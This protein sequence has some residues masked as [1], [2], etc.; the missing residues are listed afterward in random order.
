MIMNTL[1]LILLIILQ[2]QSV[3]KTETL[4]ELEVLAQHI[5][6]DE[7]KN[8]YV[9]D[10]PKIMVYD[11]AGFHDYS[12]SNMYTG[13]IHSIDVSNPEQILLFYKEDQGIRFIN[14]YFRTIPQPFS[15]TEKGYQDVAAACVSD[16]D[17]L[18]IFENGK[19]QLTKL[20]TQGDFITQGLTLN[21]Q[22]G[23][24]IHPAYMLFRNGTLY[25][26]D[27]EK[28]IFLFNPIGQYLETLPIKGVSQFR[29]DDGNLIYTLDSTAVFYNLETRNN[30]HF[31][32]PFEVS[33]NTLADLQGNQLVI[34]YP[35]KNAIEVKAV[36]L[37][38]QEK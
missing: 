10:G 12:F 14:Q 13:T 11:P 16:D 21:E 4:L 34:Y 36:K 2:T 35:G 20:S 32:L 26:S 22:I 15:L 31:K 18:Y 30:Q 29:I 37:S 33:N 7:A 19:Q 6:I 1:W 8:I 28:G 38:K 3:Q 25:V 23:Q 5:S 27:P 24:T 9:V 17:N